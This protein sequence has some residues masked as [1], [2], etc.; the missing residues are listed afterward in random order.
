M[1]GWGR[2]PALPVLAPGEHCSW[3][4]SS[5]GTTWG[6]QWACWGPCVQHPCP[7]HCC[8]P[9]ALG[10][11]QGLQMLP[12]CCCRVSA[13]SLHIPLCARHVQSLAQV[14]AGVPG[15]ATLSHPEAGSSSDANR[16][17]PIWGNVFAALHHGRPWP[18]HAIATG[19]GG[20]T[21]PPNNHSGCSLAPATAPS[22]HPHPA[23]LQGPRGPLG[24]LNMAVP[25]PTPR[26]TCGAGWNH[27][28]CAHPGSAG[29]SGLVSGPTVWI[30][31]AGASSSSGCRQ[32]EGTEQAVRAQAGKSYCGSGTRFPAPSQKELWDLLLMSWQAWEGH[33]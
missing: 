20:Q 12:I 4:E 33:H 5:G 25:Q 21:C 31:V 9:L 8:D 23:A 17:C 28:S 30:P 1:T 18:W 7:R 16:C 10:P 27:T 6:T 2:D 15:S 29:A 19:C 3:G 24:L 11:G 26:D 32:E 22:L 13:H 14:C